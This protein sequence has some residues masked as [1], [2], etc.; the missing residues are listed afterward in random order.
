MQVLSLQWRVTL[1]WTCISINSSLFAAATPIASPDAAALPAPA[2]NGK[3]SYTCTSDSGDIVFNWDTDTR[4]ADTFA[5]R[6]FPYC[7]AK[8]LDDWETRRPESDTDLR[9]AIPDGLWEYRTEAGRRTTDPS[10][11]NFELSQHPMI[12]T[13]DV[14]SW[15]DVKR[16]IECMS[17][18]LD[19][20]EG[21]T[22]VPSAEIWVFHTQDPLAQV[23][24][25]KIWPTPSV[26]VGAG[27]EGTA[28]PIESA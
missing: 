5:K 20:L 28:V 15:N 7:I 24:A 3:E 9:N 12:A 18:Y 1:W 27:G 23:A 14:F 13:G 25:G 2:A 8:T 21:Q 6:T 17:D 11:F 10:F 4:V 16:A 26:A 19:Q 22:V